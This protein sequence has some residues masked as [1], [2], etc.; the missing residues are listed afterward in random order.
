MR[1]LFIALTIIASL[2]GCNQKPKETPQK[3][4]ENMAEDTAEKAAAPFVW[5][6]ANIYFLLTDRFLSQISYN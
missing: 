2:F 4:T 1:K 3:D 5:E 6:G